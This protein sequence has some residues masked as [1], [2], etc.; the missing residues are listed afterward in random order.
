MP[1]LKGQKQ[2]SSFAISGQMSFEK[3]SFE[4][5]FWHLFQAT[6]TSSRTRAT[7][8]CHSYKTFFFVIGGVA[9]IS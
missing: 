6:S 3:M 7:N 9:K 4:Q 5:Q 1:S 2:L 8:W